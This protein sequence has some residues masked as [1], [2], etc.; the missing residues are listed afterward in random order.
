MVDILIFCKHI[1]WGPWIRSSILFDVH[2][3]MLLSGFCFLYILDI[4]LMEW[5]CNLNKTCFFDHYGWQ[6]RYSKWFVTRS[7]WLW[8]LYSLHCH[9]VLHILFISKKKTVSK[10]LPWFYISNTFKMSQTNMFLGF[11]TVIALKCFKTNSQHVFLRLMYLLFFRWFGFSVWRPCKQ[12]D[13][14]Q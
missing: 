4:M 3:F 8:L 13:Q 2:I 1:T 6:L 9:L 14:R 10:I 7:M 11:K 5:P 12:I